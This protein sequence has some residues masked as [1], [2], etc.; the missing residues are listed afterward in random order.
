MAKNLMLQGTMS[1]AGKS[2]LTAGILRVLHQDGYSVAPF[3]SQ[4]MA[5]NSYV[6]KDG[7]EIGRAQA[8]QAEAAGIAPS[9]DMNPILLKPTGDTGSQVILNGLPIGDMKAS[10]YYQQKQRLMPEVL[11]AYERLSLDYDIIVIEGAGSPVEINLRENDIVNMGLAEA[12]DAPVLLVGN[13]DPGGVFAQLLGTLELMSE[14]E[15]ARVAGLVINK[16]RGDASLLMPGLSMF[17]SYS[18]IPFAGIVPYIPMALDEED[19]VSERLN[20]HPDIRTKGDRFKVAVIRFPYISNYTDFSIFENISGVELSYIATPKELKDSD[21]II[22]PGT[23][24]TLHD[25]K[26]MKDNGIAEKLKG[27]LGSDIP[28]IGI[29]GGLQMLGRSITDEAKEKYS[30]LGFLPLDTFFEAN[31][32]KTLRQTNGVIGSLNGFF[33]G[34]S[35]IHLSGYEIHMGNSISDRDSFPVITEGNVL[36]TYLHGIFDNVD[37]TGRLI[38]SDNEFIIEPPARQRERELNRLADVL[39]QALDWKLIYQ[40]IGV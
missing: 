26:W 13:I 18:S 17:K 39:R 22:L 40:A 8:L 14:S 27:F 21:M 25:L 2:I 16:F 11:S 12:V 3:K 35:G 36:G 19:S 20:R 1:G 7:R 38:G 5:L 23:K 37:F 30:A 6:T 9:S 4:N 24:N 10:E 34:L 32:D 31:N 15:R 28:I 33:S 29:C